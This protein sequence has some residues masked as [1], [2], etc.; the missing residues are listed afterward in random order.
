MPRT[1]LGFK[2]L[3]TWQEK[4]LVKNLNAM[5]SLQSEF[6]KLVHRINQEKFVPNT[7]F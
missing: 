3:Q 6:C 1:R 7:L 4:T 2:E 5:S